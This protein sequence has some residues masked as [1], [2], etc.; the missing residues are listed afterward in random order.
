MGRRMHAF[1]AHGVGGAV[2]PKDLLM[3]CQHRWLQTTRSHFQMDLA[4]KRQG[5]AVTG[6]W[7]RIEGCATACGTIPHHDCPVQCRVA[8]SPHIIVAYHLGTH[9]QS[10]VVGPSWPSDVTSRLMTQY[11]SDDE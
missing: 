1:I 2:K 11:S 10:P 9:L 4:D 8:D 7:R 6:Q 3:S 5:R